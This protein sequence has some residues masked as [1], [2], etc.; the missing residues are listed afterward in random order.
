M[1]IRERRR[2]IRSPAGCDLTRLFFGDL[3]SAI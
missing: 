1:Q 2:Q 3:E